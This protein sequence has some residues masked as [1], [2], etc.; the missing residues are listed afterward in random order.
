M[1]SFLKKWFGGASAAPPRESRS[2]ELG[3]LIFQHTGEVIRAEQALQRAGFSVEIKGPPPHLRTGCDMVLVFPLMKEFAVRRVLEQAN[4]KPEG[5]VPMSGEMPEPVSLLKSKD[6]GQ[7]LMVQAANV[8]ITVEKS[9]GIIVNVSG[10]GCP[11]VPWLAGMLTGKSIREAEEPKVNG[12]SLCSYA[13]QKAFAEARR[14]LDG[15]EK[16]DA[17]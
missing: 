16:E 13:L 2:M 5:V 6:F 7:W 15:M 14:L 1:L 10:G 9:S 3:F 17:S 8:K 4:L 11:D 12:Q